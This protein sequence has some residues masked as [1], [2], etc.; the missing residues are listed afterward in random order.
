LHHIRSC[1]EPLSYS[2]FFRPL[3][4]QLLDRSAQLFSL[5]R[6]GTLLRYEDDEGDMITLASDDDLA[7][8]FEVADVK[9]GKLMLRLEVVYPKPARGAPQPARGAPAPQ[10]PASIR[11]D[12]RVK[13][14]EA[15]A[16]KLEKEAKKAAK[17]A[18]KMA[19][20]M[21]KEAKKAAKKAA[22]GAE[23]A[24]KEAKKA[25]NNAI[26]AFMA[27]PA[28]A[29]LE[30]VIAALTPRGSSER[31][32]PSTV[33]EAMDRLSEL[34]TQGP[35]PAPVEESRDEK[36]AEPPVVHLNVTCDASGMAPIVGPRFK[37]KGANYDLCEAEYAKLSPPDQAHFIRIDTPDQVWLPRCSM[38]R[39]Q[40]NNAQTAARLRAAFDGR[41]GAAV[42]PQARFVGDV[43]IPDNTEI[44]PGTLFTKIWRLSNTGEPPWPAN[45]KL[46]CVGGDDF[47]G[48]KF[49]EVSSPVESGSEVDVAVSL[50]A[51]P[52]PGRYVSYWRLAE[53]PSMRK[54]GQRIWVQVVIVNSDGTVEFQASE[55]AEQAIHV[56]VECDASGMHPV[57]GPRFNKKG[58]DYDLCEAEYAKLDEA[59][60][61]NYL[62]IDHPG[63]TPIDMASGTSVVYDELEARL[64][65]SAENAATAKH[66]EFAAKIEK[67]QETLPREVFDGLVDAME[68]LFTV[69]PENLEACL[70][71]AESIIT[72]AGLPSMG[73][74]DLESI[75][76]MVAFHAAAFGAPPVASEP[77]AAVVEEHEPLGPFF[78]GDM[79]EL[80][81]EY[82]C[83]AYPEEE[84]NDWHYVTLAASADGDHLVWANRAIS[85][86]LC[87]T[88]EQHAYTVGEECPYAE[89]HPIMRIEEVDGTLTLRGPHGESY[90]RN[91]EVVSEEGD[92]YEE[93]SEEA[94]PWSMPEA[95]AQLGIEGDDLSASTLLDI[96]Q[97]VA[98][99]TEE[100][101]RL[102][103]EESLRIAQE[104]EAAAAAEEFQATAEEAAIAAWD[105]AVAEEARLADEEEAAAIA[106][107]VAEAEAAAAASAEAAMIEAG[108]LAAEEAQAAAAAK[109]AVE[110]KAA[111]AKAAEELV[112]EEEAARQEE[113]VRITAEAEAKA[114]ENAA[115]L[116]PEM[117][118]LVASLC[119]MGFA[120]EASRSAIAATEGNLEEAAN[121]LLTAGD[122]AL[123]VQEPAAPE[124][125][126]LPPV[127][128]VDAETF[129][130]DEIAPAPEEEEDD[131]NGDWD[132][133]LEELVEMGFENDGL[134]RELLVEANGNVKDAVKEL[135]TRERSIRAESGSDGSCEQA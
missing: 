20:A 71:E 19:A 100:A 73:A 33:C 57:V 77:A 56:G 53:P 3:F 66:S 37:K 84:R 120:E 2:L 28:G 108:R 52:M 26:P 35:P 13:E 11:D 59:E 42:K 117:E 115:N 27:T 10:A 58:L 82:T 61:G 72:E 48:D 113:A 38:R 118:P 24:A 65:W 83:S 110:A 135:V 126:E 88:G 122:A 39:S 44:L 85:W 4:G 90:S 78:E 47:D 36:P 128:V 79:L 80:V 45:T 91:A 76:E 106:A 43:N 62:R 127:E 67:L 7:E 15:Q 16:A 107:H 54:F 101:E 49:T 5:P 105:K 30:Q 17:H 119:A 102:A 22:K 97:A 51:P 111:A 94:S 31:P 87:P 64:G 50:V 95:I 114:V 103:A 129:P 1:P 134:N 75:R 18:E 32:T 132:Y 96:E 68:P 99:N 93:A 46:V 29:M 98:A 81:G 133:L 86:K 60:K 63:A 8:A 112:A 130:V 89:T 34:V 123:A 14:L 109:E 131:W 23:N 124:A 21:E 25:V 121:I 116:G 9:G 74:L 92:L 104:V 125:F 6:D 69:P 70:A 40:P 12:P 55:E 41:K